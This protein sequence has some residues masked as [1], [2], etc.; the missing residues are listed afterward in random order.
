MF[1]LI[2]HAGMLAVAF[3]LSALPFLTLMGLAVHRH[4]DP[5][6]GT[7]SAILLTFVPPLM[8]G[9]L[10]PPWRRVPALAGSLALWSAALFLALPVYF[11][12]ER[13]EAFVTA[14]S[15]VG[16]GRDLGDLPDRLADRLP[17]DPAV[18][19][20]ALPE[21]LPVVDPELPA[22]TEGS[23]SLAIPY[24]GQGRRMSVPVVFGNDQHELEL[25]MMFDTGATY[26]TLTTEVLEQLGIRPGPDDPVIVL[27]TA[28]GE[29]E[30]RIVLVDEVWLGNLR[31]TNVAIATCDVCGSDDTA[32]LLG[33]N[34]SGGFNLQI[35][36]DRREVVFQPRARFDR[37]LDV[38]PFTE[39]GATFSRFPGG[40]VEMEVRV[41]NHADRAVRSVS[42][43][44][45]CAEGAWVVPLGQV[46]A[47]DR[48]TVK[49][50]L[51]RHPPC[52]TYSVAMDE[53]HW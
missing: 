27:H 13:R 41:D 16:L 52:E 26:T 18:S 40:R 53:A 1:T 36:A 31:V 4:A 46:P 15:L 24:E 32:G 8:A 45:E 34:V 17:D 14:L 12:G 38:K 43:R 42:A 21:A 6:A 10:S 44:I 9:A 48:Q 37:Q 35:D 5:V 20:P 28:N 47:G 23:E 11:P 7:V 50:K 33:L 49:Q 30:A 25:V 29:R 19:E 2:G 22:S 51:P 39:L 3:S